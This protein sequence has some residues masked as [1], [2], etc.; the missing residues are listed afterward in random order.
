MIL[1]YRAHWVDSPD[2]ADAPLIVRKAPMLRLT[3]VM[4]AQPFS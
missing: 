3:D 1:L 4:G 2:G